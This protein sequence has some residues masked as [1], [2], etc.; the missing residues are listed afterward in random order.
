MKISFFYIA[1]F[2]VN[3]FLSL[4]PKKIITLLE[5]LIFYHIF[6]KISINRI[7]RSFGKHKKLCLSF[8][9]PQLST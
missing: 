9:S 7:P 6:D 1:K 4:A 3:D 2:L 8:H 5:W